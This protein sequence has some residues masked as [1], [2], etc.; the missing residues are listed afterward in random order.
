MFLKVKT[1]LKEN[2]GSSLFLR[3][4]SF[5]RLKSLPRCMEGMLREAFEIMKC[6][7]YSAVAL[8]SRTEKKH[9]LKYPLYLP[10]S[11]GS[12]VCLGKFSFM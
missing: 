1:D 11:S 4:F 9:H 8:K 7:K 3:Y 10:I 5:R 6:L 12:G 2:I